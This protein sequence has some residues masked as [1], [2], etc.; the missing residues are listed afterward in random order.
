MANYSYFLSLDG[1]FLNILTSLLTGL[2]IGFYNFYFEF[3]SQVF[4]LKTIL[5]LAGVVT[6]FIFESV[7]IV[8][9]DYELLEASVAGSQIDSLRCDY[10][11]SIYS[12][13]FYI[14]DRITAIIGLS[15][16]FFFNKLDKSSLI[17]GRKS[18]F[19]TLNGVFSI[20]LKTSLLSYPE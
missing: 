5:S 12:N 8:I 9:F 13:I 16:G 6:I 19:L 17:E 7:L 10:P 1:P 20:L 2:T 15:Q 14:V 4:L 3:I 18:S 11:P